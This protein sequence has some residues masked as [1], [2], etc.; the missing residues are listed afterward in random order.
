VHDV[1]LPVVTESGLGVAV[2]WT[3]SLKWS[4]LRWMQAGATIKQGL[5][6]PGREDASIVAAASFAAL[7]QAHR[8]DRH[9][10]A[11]D[12]GLHAHRNSVPLI[13]ASLC[14]SGAV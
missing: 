2:V 13:D 14:L 6:V 5:H 1:S 7:P 11:E 8:P 12:R 9:R 3:L 10:D 4:G